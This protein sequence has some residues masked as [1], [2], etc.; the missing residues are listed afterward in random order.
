MKPIFINEEYKQHLLN[1]FKN[2]LDTAR[3]QNNTLNF[4]TTLTIDVPKTTRPIVNITNKAY[5]KMLLYV[6]DTPTEI[7]WHGTVKRDQKYN[8]YTITDVFLYPQTLSSATVTTDQ[9]KYNQWCEGLDD[10]TY[11]NMRFQG[12][13]HVNFGATP[14]GVDT[15]YYKD[16]LQVLPKNDFYIFMILNK[17][18]QFSIFI[19]DLALNTIFETA[20]IDIIIG[21]QENLTANIDIEKTKHCVKPTINYPTRNWLE[22]CSPFKSTCYQGSAIYD[23]EYPPIVEEEYPSTVDKIFED[24]DKKYKNT[25]LIPKK[26]KGKK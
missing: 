7:A 20:D 6:L 12:H 23:N 10:D 22:G 9:E 18:R 14:S 17:S 19:Y 26:K 4:S 25:Q 11:N 2:Y 1:K 24:I 13:S 8:I 16:I 5:L 21:E 15:A 3:L